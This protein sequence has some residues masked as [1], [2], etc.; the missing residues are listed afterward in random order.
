MK[1]LDRTK[2]I[3]IGILILAVFGVAYFY[4][5]KGAPESDVLTVGDIPPGEEGRIGKE[6]L[7]I[8]A[9]LQALEIDSVVFDDPA[10]KQLK[11]ITVPVVSEPLGRD[12]PFEKSATSSK[13]NI[14]RN[15]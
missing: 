5:S 8:L 2:E 6:L 11:D 13:V 7:A 14:I 15:Q 3:I 10:W 12:N 4:Y 1:Y 9:E